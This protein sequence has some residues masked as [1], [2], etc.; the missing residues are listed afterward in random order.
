M[1]NIEMNFT[2]KQSPYSTTRFVSPLH[3]LHALHGNKKTSHEHCT[4]LA[5]EK[6]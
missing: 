5:P 1:R 4:A 6:Q 2:R 3:Y